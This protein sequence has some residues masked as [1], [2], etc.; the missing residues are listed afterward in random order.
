[1]G[2]WTSPDGGTA[3]PFADRDMRAVDTSSSDTGAS[4]KSDT[5]EL[6]R[7]AA[8]APGSGSCTMTCQNRPVPFRSSTVP[9]PAG[10]GAA[11]ANRRLIR[12]TF[13]R[14]SS[15]V[16]ERIIFPSRSRPTWVLALSNSAI[17]WLLNAGL[18]CV[19]TV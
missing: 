10:S 18:L 13:C 9:S 3:A 12:R 15:R 8:T 6:P 14:R 4:S 17:E 2:A 11:S 7:R 1:M 5:P 16:V 19:C